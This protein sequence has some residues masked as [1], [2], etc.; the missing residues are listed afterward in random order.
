MFV[1]CIPGEKEQAG[2]LWAME[3]VMNRA[4]CTAPNGKCLDMESVGA[5]ESH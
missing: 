3:G 5:P 4:I 1:W 2:E